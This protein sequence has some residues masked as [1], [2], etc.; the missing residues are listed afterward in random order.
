MNK[1]VWLL[2]L[3]QALLMS[4][5]V[6]LISVNGL[7]G[8]S[9]S[10]SDTWVT[11]PVATQF[12]G[13]MMATIPASLIMA[14]IGR[15]K[16]FILGNIFGI[17]GALLCVVALQQQD[18]WFFCVCTLLLGIG[19]GFA[20]L[21]RFAAI[22]VSA[23]EAKS[24]AISNQ[25]LAVSLLRCLAP[26]SPIM[27]QH[28][29]PDANFIGAFGALTVLYILAL[30]IL[31]LVK[32]PALP[33]KEERIKPNSF[34]TIFATPGYLLTVFTALVAYTVMN[35][36]M[37]VTP[38]A[39]HKHGFSFESAAIVIEWHVLGMFAPAFVT[40]HIIDKIGTRATVMMGAMLII[41][42]TVI[43]IQGVSEWHFRIAL[44]LLGVGWNFMFVGATSALTNYYLPQDKARA[45]AFNEFAVFGSVT[46]SAML[47]G[48]LEATFGWQL[49]NQITLP[50]MC[51][52]LVF[53]FFKS[54]SK[55][56]LASS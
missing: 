7:I 52:V 5:N 24:R 36:L 34:S 38:I 3:C 16:G 10:P 19:I 42:C 2:A 33:S 4:G 26:I 50:L 56:A 55:P 8:Q 11:L 54:R 43:N 14:R 49:L 13:M 12:V 21:Y 1:N 18:F 48:Y 20:T 32:F 45:Q 44:L 31:Q 35:L 15:K 27:S 47:S 29:L 46:V 22:E 17:G 40:G 37:T 28:M 23:P 53:Y 25:W 9:L 30:G 39:M 6:L 41:L 51:T